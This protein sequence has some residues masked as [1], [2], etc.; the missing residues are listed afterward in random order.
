[1]EWKNEKKKEI[2]KEKVDVGSRRRDGRT[3][4]DKGSGRQVRI[5]VYI[6]A[7]QFASQKNI[8]A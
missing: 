4:A 3:T 2:R 1:M 5:I 6:L 8:S 7:L